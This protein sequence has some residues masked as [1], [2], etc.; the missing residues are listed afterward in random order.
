M[1]KISDISKEGAYCCQYHRKT[2]QMFFS[3]NTVLKKSVT[4]D[5]KG[6]IK[7]IKVDSQQVVYDISKYLEP[8]AAVLENVLTS[9]G[10]EILNQIQYIAKSLTVKSCPCFRNF[11]YDF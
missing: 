7:R 1:I 8:I 5:S 10:E 3:Q 2:F 9:G 6:Q 11:G 4:S